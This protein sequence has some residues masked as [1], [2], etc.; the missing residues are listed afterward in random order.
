MDVP[1]TPSP[2]D[3]NA[4][5]QDSISHITSGSVLQCLPTSSPVHSTSSNTRIAPATYINTHTPLASASE[6]EGTGGHQTT[7]EEKKPVGAISTKASKEC[8]E[9][10]RDKEKDTEEGLVEGVD[11]MYEITDEM[12]EKGIKLHNLLC[13]NDHFGDFDSEEIWYHLHTSYSVYRYS[14]VCTLINWKK[15]EKNEPFAAPLPVLHH[16][17]HLQAYL[18][19]MVNNYQKYDDMMNANVTLSASV[20]HMAFDLR[21][22][23]EGITKVGSSVNNLN[24]NYE[25]LLESVGIVATDVIGAGL[26]HMNRVF[27]DYSA[28]HA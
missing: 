19:D 1:N 24:V 28:N 27:S 5:V 22:I 3:T 13:D 21:K 17:D 10:R 4:Q 26:R 9:G 11:Y 2:T 8:E 23:G 25:D 15:M 6:C 16:M 14:T 7:K 12:M 20:R 18:L